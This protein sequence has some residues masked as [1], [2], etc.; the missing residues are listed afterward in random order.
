MSRQESPFDMQIKLLMI[1]DSG[2][3]KTC[4]LLRYA[5]SSFSPTFIT[6]IGI[7]F[8]IKNIELG[9]KRIKLQIWDTA[10][11][12]RFR[13]ITT[14]YFR[15]AQ[16]IL[17]VYDVTD[18]SSFNSIRNWVGQINQHADVHVNKI[19]IGNKCDMQDGRVVSTEEG[20]ALAQEYKI[21]F[22]ETSAKTDIMVEDG[23]LAISSDVKDR[24]VS[25]GRPGPT[26]KNININNENSGGSGKGC[27]C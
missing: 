9:G 13:T 2:V 17:L 25:E 24:L 23:F 16:G 20:E 22:Y 27:P 1:G 11:Q 8:K 3:G 18:R 12:E 7:D 26:G 14:S 15:G 21:K 10:G 6:T 5:N 4:L 19:L